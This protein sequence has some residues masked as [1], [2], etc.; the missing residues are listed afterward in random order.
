MQDKVTN[1]ESTHSQEIFSEKF[2]PQLHFTPIRNWINDPNG[3]LFYKGKYHLFYQHN[4]NGD[5]WGDMSWGHA[6]S[7]D[8]F[9]WNELPTAISY[10]EK[11]GI[12]SGS[13]VVDHNNTSGFGS[14]ENPPLVAIYT[15]HQN[16]ESNQSQHIA[17]SLDEG[18]TWVKYANN[19]VLDL[20]MKDFR[21]PKVFWDE[22]RQSW[23]MVVSKPLEFK[24]AFFTSPDLKNWSHLSDFGP[25][26]ATGGCWECP[27]L[28][29]LTTPSGI[30]QWVLL[31]SLNPGGPT[32]GS[33]TQYFIG[34]WDGREFTPRQSQE[35]QWLDHGRDNYA[36]VTFS[37]TDNR[38]IFIGWMS[39]WEYA[40]K[41]ETSP[42]RGAMTLPREL[43]LSS[44][45]GA[46]QLH[47]QP[48][49]E[50][51]KL[52]GEY[53]GAS[54]QLELQEIT[55]Q[56]ISSESL[57]IKVSDGNG[58]YFEFGYSAK[59]KSL[60][61]DRYHAWFGEYQSN[62]QENSVDSGN[63][64]MQAIIDRGSIELSTK[65]GKSLIT[66]LHLLDGD[67]Y[68]IE[69]INGDGSKIKRRRLFTTHS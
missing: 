47:L 42:W 67:F 60:F 24:I 13:A 8:L 57:T 1:M 38:R 49:A 45:N 48:A 10:T 7:T 3:L 63:F 29:P 19:P 16:D 41:I 9:H 12:F 50:F 37:N 26:G 36:G 51:S 64:I 43:S 31:V 17:Y 4:P 23:T 56:I 21:D 52:Q 20:G 54:D 44:N 55:A 2:R 5:L 27:D 18:L 35:A 61:V 62:Y 39:N 68:N 33:G 11:E 25:L 66:S 58:R 69:V 6:V 28:F 32:G 22:Q 15:V 53:V 65:S 40:S 14:V 30:T 46:F 34:D 59:K